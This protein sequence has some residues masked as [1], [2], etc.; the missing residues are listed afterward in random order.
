MTRH[1]ITVEQAMDEACEIAQQ[2]FR[3]A[4]A[5][6]PATDSDIAHVLLHFIHK[7]EAGDISEFTIRG[8]NRAT[9]GVDVDIKGTM[10]PN[11]VT[12]DLRVDRGGE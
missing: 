2:S 11:N 4:Y 6:M 9:R 10:K 8:I 3:H 7:L 1:I 12:I 5:N